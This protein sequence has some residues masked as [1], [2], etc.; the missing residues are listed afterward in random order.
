V[1]SNYNTI[2]NDYES[3]VKKLKEKEK[4]IEFLEK[5]VKRRTDEFDSMV[6]ILSF[7]NT[8][9]IIIIIILCN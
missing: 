4:L 5:E 9:H 8:S 2:L 1:S 3:T 6:T 7:Y